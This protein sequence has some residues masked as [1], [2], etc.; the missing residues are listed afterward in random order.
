MHKQL[1]VQ[2][3]AEGL[4]GLEAD[5]DITRGNVRLDQE[6]RERFAQRLRGAGGDG[7]AHGNARCRRLPGVPYGPGVE[8]PSG[9]RLEAL[10]PQSVQRVPLLQHPVLVPVGQQRFLLHKRVDTGEAPGQHDVRRGPVRLVHV[11]NNARVEV[12]DLGA[13]GQQ[14]RKLVGGVPE[15]VAQ[16]VGGAPGRDVRPQQLREVRAGAGS[17]Q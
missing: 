4:E 12:D 16:V 9:E 2:A 11:D 7:G 1:G 6:Q 10:D 5:G 13:V 8:R 3:R 14:S 17:A 15:R